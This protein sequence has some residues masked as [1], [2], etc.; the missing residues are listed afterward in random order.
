MAHSSN[1]GDDHAGAQLG[2]A[3]LEQ[4][5][6]AFGLGSKTGIGLPGESAGIL[7]TSK[8]WSAS[9]AANVPIGQG[10]S[11]TTLQMAS[12][13]Q[14]IANGGVRIPPRIV[15][16]VTAPDGTVDAAAGARRAPG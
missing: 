6:R 9:R 11:V 1:V 3:T 16:S 13:Y 10:V 4:Y 8:D 7:Q 12:I 5:M 15:A 2:N 14:T